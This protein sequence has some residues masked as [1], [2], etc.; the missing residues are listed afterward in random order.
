[1]NNQKFIVV[2]IDFYME[3]TEI[4]QDSDCFQGFHSPIYKMLGYMVLK[5]QKLSRNGH[6]DFGT[7][8]S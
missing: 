6:L 5:L 2:F 1:M 8:F 4:Q 7:C 3:V